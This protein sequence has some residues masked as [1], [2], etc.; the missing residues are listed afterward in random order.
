M[1]KPTIDDHIKGFFAILFLGLVTLY[2]ALGFS[3]VCYAI[4]LFFSGAL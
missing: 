3:I 2:F 1:S 4:F